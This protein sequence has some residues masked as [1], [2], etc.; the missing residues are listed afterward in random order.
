MLSLVNFSF[1]RFLG[2]SAMSY[3]MKDSG[4]GGIQDILSPLGFAYCLSLALRTYF[5]VPWI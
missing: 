3:E 2:A 5:K 1:F 4:P